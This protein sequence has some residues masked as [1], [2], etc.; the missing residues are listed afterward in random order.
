MFCPHC[1]TDISKTQGYVRLIDKMNDALVF[2]DQHPALGGGSVFSL[3]SLLWYSAQEICKR[4]Y[5]RLS[6]GEIDVH[7]T[8]H[9]YKRY[10]KLFDEEFKEIEPELKTLARISVPYETHFGEPWKFDHVEYWGE[11]SFV[12]FEGMDFKKYHDN[13]RWDHYSGTNTSGRSF[14]ELIINTAKEFKK[15]F[16]DF[17]CE[18]F[19][20]EEEKENHK[21]EKSIF[22]VKCRD[23]PKLS[24]MK[25][26]SKYM[27]VTDA[28][29]NRRWVKWFSKTPYA[30][31]NWSKDCKLILSGKTTRV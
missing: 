5:M 17:S 27:R 3:N 1:G 24:W 8:P 18:D 9:N 22:F 30:K 29:F 23:N 6:D 11:L 20:T 19:L 10:K 25:H 4:G 26:N 2:L 7:Y 16:G 28:E 14:E 15:I 12:M 13:S 31:K 21:I